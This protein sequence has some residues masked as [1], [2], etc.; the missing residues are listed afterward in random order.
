MGGGWNPVAQGQREVQSHFPLGLFP[1]PGF[2]GF[3]EKFLTLLPTGGFPLW[4]NLFSGKPLHR[5]P[6]SLTGVRQY[7][8]VYK[9]RSDVP[10]SIFV[11]PCVFH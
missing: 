1:G 8:I 3:H 4:G 10:G 11:Q 5:P 2:M 9:P 6:D 7:N